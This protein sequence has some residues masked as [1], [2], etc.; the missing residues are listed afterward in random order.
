[1][2]IVVALGGNALLRRGEPMTAESAARQH[3]A[4][5]P[6]RWR[7]SI[8]ATSSSSH[9]ATGR[10][11]GCWRCRRGLQTGRGLS[12]RRARGADRGH[13]RLR[14]RAGARQPAALRGAVRDHADDG[15]G[16]SATIRRSPIRPSSS[17]PSTTKPSRR[18]S[19]PRR[20]GPSRRTATSGGASCRRRCP[21]ASSR[22]GR[23]SGCS[24]TGAVVICAGGGGIP[25]MYDRG[26]RELVG[27]EAVIDKDLC[28]ELLAASSTPTSSSWRPTPRRSSP[29]GASRRRARSAALTRTRCAATSFPAGSMGPKVDAAC[30]FAEATGKAAAIGALKDL[31]A[32]VRGAAGTT[33]TNDG[34]GSRMGGLEAGPLR[35]NRPRFRGGMT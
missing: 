31:P 7:R 19:P 11:S 2:R 9:T 1:M 15:R 17:A 16:R 21:S 4:L 27:V 30:H 14:D 13:D 22:C 26:T 8:R 23:S 18:R 5:P 10:R 35:R 12:A 6:K 24:R 3:R 29:T 33:I 25:T 20:A 32:I 28:S 34:D